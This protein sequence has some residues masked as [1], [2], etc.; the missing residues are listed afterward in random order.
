MNNYVL[1][2]GSMIY[3]DHKLV[4]SHKI[5]PFLVTKI[6]ELIKQTKVLSMFNTNELEQTFCNSWI[7]KHK[8]KFFTKITYYKE[9]DIDI[10]NTFK[11]LLWHNN[12][13]KIAKIHQQW[14]KLFGEYLQIDL[15]GFKNSFIEI[16]S[17]NVNKGSGNKEFC[18]ISNI[19]PKK[20]IHI[21]DSMNDASTKGQIGYLCALKNS[22]Q[23]LKNIADF[24][25]EYSCGQQGLVKFID[26]KIDWKNHNLK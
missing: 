5:D 17:K 25:S 7:L 4:K 1:A 26:K 22:V 19:D 8:A 20:A 11:I 14:N 15:S 18:L 13:K 24:I 21:G 10:N 3:K 9:K 6:L 12:P 23:E 16:T 2:N